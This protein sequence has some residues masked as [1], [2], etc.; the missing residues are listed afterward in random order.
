MWGGDGRVGWG[1]NPG[2][3]GGARA[4]VCVHAGVLGVS[5]TLSP[6]NK[7][8]AHSKPHRPPCMSASHHRWVTVQ[9]WTVPTACWG[10]ARRVPVGVQGPGQQAHGRP[11]TGVP[12]P[13]PSAREEHGHQRDQGRGTTLRRPAN[14]SHRATASEPGQTQTPAARSKGCG[15]RTQ[16]ARNQSLG[17]VRS[18]ALLST[19]PASKGSV[20]DACSCPLR[21]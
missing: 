8:M 14:Q 19:A 5:Y 16:Y 10:W 17:T 21:A 1:G 18:S 3:H 7:G 2:S 15:V 12:S 11:H 20:T 4:G 13:L 6:L 9:M